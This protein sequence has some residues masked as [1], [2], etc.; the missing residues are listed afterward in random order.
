MQKMINFLID[1]EDKLKEKM[2]LINNLKTIQDALE[3]LK[4]GEKPKPALKQVDLKP[5]PIDENYKLLNC[6]MET[7]DR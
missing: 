1:T 5:N 2:D 4:T 7:L 6:K 3:M